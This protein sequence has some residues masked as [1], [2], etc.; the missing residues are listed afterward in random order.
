MREKLVIPRLRVRKRWYEGLNDDPIDHSHPD[1]GGM[2]DAQYG[3][4]GQGQV[5]PVLHTC[6]H[7]AC[8]AASLLSNCYSAQHCQPH[9]HT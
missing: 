2:A 3:F 9:M 6:T 7:K 1:A 4:V 5:Q 8:K